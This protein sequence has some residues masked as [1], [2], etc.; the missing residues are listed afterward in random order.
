MIMV[1]VVMSV[2]MSM[3]MAM[4]MHDNELPSYASSLQAKRSSKKSNASGLDFEAMVILLIKY[5]HMLI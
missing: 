2:I 4:M 5:E 1:A 3:V